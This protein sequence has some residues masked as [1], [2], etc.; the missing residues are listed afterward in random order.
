MNFFVRTI[1]VRKAG[2]RSQVQLL[3]KLRPPIRL[4]PKRKPAELKSRNLGPRILRRPEIAEERGQ[5]RQENKPTRAE[6]KAEP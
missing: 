5:H 6:S 1:F 2:E 3:K 4:S